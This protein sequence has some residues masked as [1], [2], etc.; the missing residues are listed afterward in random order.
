ME[1]QIMSLEADTMLPQTWRQR[2]PRNA[3]KNTGF[4]VFLE[5]TRS[6]LLTFFFCFTH[7]TMKYMFYTCIYIYIM[8]C[9]AKVTARFANLHTGEKKI[10][11][12]HRCLQ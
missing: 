5:I 10:A 2:L 1:T 9:K 3:V 6:F 11:P 12:Q 7:L 8:F 4:S